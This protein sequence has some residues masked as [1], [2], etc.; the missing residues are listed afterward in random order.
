[1]SSD[2]E[3]EIEAE[4]KADNS[5]NNCDCSNGYDS[6]N[7]FIINPKFDSF[8]D[9][10]TYDNEWLNDK[11]EDNALEQSFGY[12]KDRKNRADPILTNKE[13]MI[14]LNTLK[15]LRTGSQSGVI[16]EN[17]RERA[18]VYGY[19]KTDIAEKLYDIVNFDD[20]IFQSTPLKT[21]LNRWFM[22]GEIEHVLFRQR[23]PVTAKL[24]ED[25]N[26]YKYVKRVGLNDSLEIH[27]YVTKDL[28][29][30]LL[31]NYSFCCI[32]D[33]VHGKLFD[34]INNGLVTKLCAYLTEIQLNN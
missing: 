15:F 30:E 34:D 1:M 6:D 12:P 2:K 3:A 7:P 29:S 18:F 19:I 28:Y 13:L 31:K 23:I 22:R 21:Y 10:L 16:T 26:K 4:M 25:S 24:Q 9:L 27:K 20:V 8:D 11:I 33:P 14:K 5:D 32:V 17:F